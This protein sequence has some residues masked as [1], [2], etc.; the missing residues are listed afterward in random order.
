MMQRGVRPIYEDPARFFALTY[1]TFALRELARDVVLR[2]AGRNTKAVRQLE[3]TSGG[4]KTH[5]L[6]ALR[7]L[8]HD[9]AALPNLPAVEQFRSDAGAALPPA[10]V[11][12]LAFFTPASIADAD[13]F[14]PHVTAAVRNLAAVDDAVRRD[15]RAAE[16]RFARGYP[17]HPRPD[18]PLL[19]AV[20]AARP[21]PADARHPADVRD[22]AT[23]R[24]ALGRR[25]WSGPT[26]SC[27]RRTGTASPRRRAS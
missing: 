14:L 15:R 5:T 20:D 26:C 16:E 27:R 10:R 18:R 23:G 21:L 4:G 1:P 9:P 19:R 22:R 8:A 24:G 13:A 17:F 3:L 11:A 7:H 12:A 2:L 25:P 6:V